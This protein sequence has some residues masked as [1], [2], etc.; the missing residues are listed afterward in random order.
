[1]AGVTRVFVFAAGETYGDAISVTSINRSGSVATVV[2]A[3]AHNLEQ[4]MFAT[5]AGA[6]ETEYNI[7]S[8][9]LVI[10]D[11]TFTY[12][13]QGTPTTPAP[14]T[15]TMQGSIPLGQVIIFFTRDNDANIIPSASE[16][17]TTKDKLIEI[18]K[19]L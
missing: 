1:M 10:D 11:T 8:R 6:N 9:V 3:T 2:T 18:M 17:T 15:I 4:C 7:K 19:G 5:M 12:I 14:G 16:V 13:V